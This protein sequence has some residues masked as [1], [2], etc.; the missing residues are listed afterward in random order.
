VLVLLLAFTYAWVR[1]HRNVAAVGSFF[2]V[3]HLSLAALA[4]CWTWPDNR[5]GPPFPIAAMHPGYIMLMLLE[6]DPRNWFNGEVSLWAIPCYWAALV[7][8]ILWARWWLIRHFDELA[9]RMGT[10]LQ[11]G[12]VV[13]LPS[14]AVPAGALAKASSSAAV[15]EE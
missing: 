9:E 11:W 3:V 5:G 10:P 8:N 12:Q 1:I 6:R 13:R 7:V 2:L 15:G 4:V 14:A